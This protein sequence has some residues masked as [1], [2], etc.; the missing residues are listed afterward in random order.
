MV[1]VDIDDQHLVE[2]AVARLLAGMREQPAGVQLFDADAAAAI[3]EKV[4]GSV[5]D[6]L[7]FVADF[8]AWARKGALTM[9]LR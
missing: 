3:G 5:S 8:S 6:I 4:H 9:R 1:A 2:T 7:L